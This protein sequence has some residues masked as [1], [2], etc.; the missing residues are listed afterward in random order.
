MQ[1]VRPAGFDVLTSLHFPQ[2]KFL[3]IVFFSI[4]NFYQNPTSLN[5][6]KHYKM[7]NHPKYAK[8]LNSTTAVNAGSQTLAGQCAHTL[9]QE[10]VHNLP[11]QCSKGWATT[12]LRI[13]IYI[14]IVS[15]W[16]FARLS[17]KKY[18]L[19]AE[20]VASSWNF[21]LMCNRPPRVFLALNGFCFWCLDGKYPRTMQK[22]VCIYIYISALL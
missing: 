11:K 22:D 14:Y 17:L 19:F 7:F 6:S 9:S 3:R 18:V 16:F 8:K 12:I 1:I 4:L 15:C 10:L 20:H 13:Y 5:I 2:S 21:H